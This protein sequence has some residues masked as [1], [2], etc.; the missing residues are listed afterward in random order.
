MSCLGGVLAAVVPWLVSAQ[1]SPQ[2]RT[3][4]PDVLAPPAAPPKRAV[5]E[6]FRDTY[7]RA[8]RPRIVIYWNRELDDELTDRKTQH[9]D[10]RAAGIEAGP[11]SAGAVRID[12]AESISNRAAGGSVPRRLAAVETAFVQTMA[13]HGVRLA[14]RAAILRIEHARSRKTKGGTQLASADTRANEIDALAAHADLLLE[15][16]VLESGN[17]PD[18]VEFKVIAKNTQSGAIPFSLTTRAHGQVNPAETGFVAG[19]S[20]F[21]RRASPPRSMHDVGRQLAI[22]TM[23]AWNVAQARK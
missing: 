7:A 9:V 5:Q 3:G 20:G 12:S 11:V 16:G 1:P 2:Y 14:D 23:A 8:G 4:L 13:Q 22:D 19:E 17:G 18:E 10:I 15:I 6:Q 21:V